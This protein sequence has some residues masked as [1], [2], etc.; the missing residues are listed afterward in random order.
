MA[1]GSDEASARS[2][3]MPEAPVVFDERSSE[4]REPAESESSLALD[5]N[6]SGPGARDPER[7]T[8]FS[9]LDDVFDGLES[10][11][12]S[13]SHQQQPINTSYVEEHMVESRGDTSRSEYLMMIQGMVSGIILTSVC[14]ALAKHV[15]QMFACLHSWNLV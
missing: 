14:F 11:S 2:V 10:K 12:E 8:L 3:I 15:K 13:E 4:V 5:R 7:A 9:Q 1:S 6:A